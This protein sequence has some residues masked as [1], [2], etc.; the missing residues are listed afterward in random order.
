MWNVASTVHP[1]LR[2]HKTMLFGLSIRN[3]NKI[4][5][6]LVWFMELIPFSLLCLLESL[7]INVHPALSKC[8]KTAACRWDWSVATGCSRSFHLC[9]AHGDLH[10]AMLLQAA[11]HSFWYTNNQINTQTRFISLNTMFS[12]YVIYS[13]W[14]RMYFISS[15]LRSCLVSAISELGEAIVSVLRQM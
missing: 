6:W 15:H 9:S 1:L 10:V 14:T 8:M 4:S 11:L 3:S 5:K 2:I 12:Y 7:K 13:D